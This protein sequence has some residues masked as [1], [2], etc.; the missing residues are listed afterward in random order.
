MNEII[1]TM[2]E[3]E[4]EPGYT[5]SDFNSIDTLT[6]PHPKEG[7]R[8]LIVDDHLMSQKLL[9]LSV[10]LQPEIG[11]IDFAFSGKSAIEKAQAQ[12]YDLIFMDAVMPEMDGYEACQRLRKIPSYRNT[13]IIMVTGLTSPLDEAR[14]IIVGITNYITKPVEQKHF[15]EVV[16]REISLIEFKRK[17]NASKAV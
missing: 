6:L 2:S 1:S 10:S 5:P 8:V 4:V 15:K 3:N 11:E 14:S 17:L 12:Q 9:S 13:S 16:T 7:Y